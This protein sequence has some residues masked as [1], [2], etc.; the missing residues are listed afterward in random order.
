MSYLKDISYNYTYWLQMLVDPFASLLSNEAVAKEVKL[1]MAR[2]RA[3]LLSQIL[4]LGKAAAHH[5]L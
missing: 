1:E 5:F 2:L 3:L 4:N